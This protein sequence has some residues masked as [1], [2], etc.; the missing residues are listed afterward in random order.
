MIMVVNTAERQRHLYTQT[1]PKAPKIVV[2]FHFYKLF[3][4]DEDSS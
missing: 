3:G 2:G 1:T 4:A